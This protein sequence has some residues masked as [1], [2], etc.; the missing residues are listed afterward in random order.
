DVA[1]VGSTAGK[2]FGDG[3]VWRLAPERGVRYAK[4]VGH[5]PGFRALGRSREASVDDDRP[6]STD[7]LS[8]EPEGLGIRAIADVGCVQPL[9]ES[10]GGSFVDADPSQ[11][12]PDGI[13]ADHDG[14]EPR[15]DSPR[16]RTLSGS[17]DPGGDQQAGAAS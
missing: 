4:A 12:L 16:D 8:G 6:P 3:P 2:A 10:G 17:H 9:P 1:G 14:A 7:D 5:T 15:G 11:T 13:G